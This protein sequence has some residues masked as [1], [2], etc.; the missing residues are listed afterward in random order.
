[1]VIAPNRTLPGRRVRRPLTPPAHRIGA[2]G[3]AWSA[4]CRAVLDAQVEADIVSAIH[5]LADE[6]DALAFGA[7]EGRTW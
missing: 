3:R 2:T 5:D 6:W 7:W 1:M 4:V